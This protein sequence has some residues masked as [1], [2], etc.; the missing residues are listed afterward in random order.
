MRKRIAVIG[1]G[2]KAA[3]LAAKAHA[4]NAAGLAQIELTIFERGEIGCAWAGTDGYTNG[5]QLLCTPAER[6]V[7]FPYESQ[8]GRVVLANVQGNFSWAAFSATSGRI[9]YA[10]W[11]ARSAQRPSHAQFAAYLEW[12]IRRSDAR[13]HEQCEVTRL[14]ARSGKWSLV[15]RAMP[16]GREVRYRGF[17][18][19]VVTGAGPAKN[20]FSLTSHPLLFNG[21]D[22]WQ[23]LNEL[24]RALSSGD[25]DAPVVIVGGGGAAAAIAA[26]I[27]EAA[28][29]TRQLLF[30]A[31]Q[32][33]FYARTGSY[34]E[35]LVFDDENL[36]P[37]LGMSERREFVDRI[38]RGVVW[39]FVSERLMAASSRIAIEPGRATGLAPIAAAART[40]PGLR[41]T[42]AP[43]AM[44]TRRMELEACAVIDATGFD[45]W[46]FTQ[47]LSKTWSSKRPSA[48]EKIAVDVDHALRFPVRGLPPIH[49]PGAA[50]AQG[51]GYGSLMVLG[52][53]ADRVLRPYIDPSLL[54][55]K[56]VS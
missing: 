36:W 1:G 28:P 41:L 16:G 34:F 4:L 55:A 33:T 9:S 39:D 31:R 18:A 46:W 21:A 49:I 35:N 22:V 37:K 44:P 23:R 29:S 12:V 26:W 20:A 15:T 14:I 40:P 2:P 3:A 48:L 5:S 52:R 8:F 38:T 19:V 10:D 43:S 32:A 54:A 11:V 42:Y 45:P 47:L 27:I 56:R 24:E 13:L 6:D 50:Q 30:V 17:D 51:P 53:M 25:P 7:G